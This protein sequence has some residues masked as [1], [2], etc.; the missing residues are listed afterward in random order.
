MWYNEVHIWQTCN[1]C[2]Q[3]C[4]EK[5]LLSYHRHTQMWSAHRFLSPPH[6]RYR[7]CHP[8]YQ[9]LH[10]NH[11]VHTCH[12]MAVSFVSW[13]SA[14]ARGQIQASDK[15]V[16]PK[17]RHNKTTGV[18]VTLWTLMGYN[19]RYR[20]LTLLRLQNTSMPANSYWQVKAK[21]KV[22][23]PNNFGQISLITLVWDVGKMLSPDVSSPPT[24]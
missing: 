2:G 7:W 3:Q 20:I 5:R 11:H 15:R 17:G 10:Y 1:T 22:I 12:I 13:Y 21:S 16:G 9:P 19:S 23:S 24:V 8:G 4:I 14:E 6:Q 18:I